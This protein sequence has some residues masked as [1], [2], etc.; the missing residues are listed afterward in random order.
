M[1]N[2][3]AEAKWLASPEGRRHTAEQRELAAQ[4]RARTLQLAKTLLTEE[5]GLSEADVQ[6]LSEQEILTASGI[7]GTTDPFRA[8]AESIEANLR[9]AG[10][11]S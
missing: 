7:E 5:V 1:K 9:A 10:E 2:K 6:A 3:A 4:Q 11:E 8:G